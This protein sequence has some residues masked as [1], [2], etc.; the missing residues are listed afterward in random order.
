MSLVGKL[1]DERD[2]NLLAPEKFA[3]KNGTLRPRCEQCPFRKNSAPGWLG[4]WNVQDFEQM[5]NGDANFIC[6]SSIDKNVEHTCVGYVLIRVNSL[7]VSRDKNSMLAKLERLYQK[8]KNKN[9]CFQWWHEFAAH[10][11]VFGVAK[12]AAAGGK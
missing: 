3:L 1:Q 5:Y 12:R 9:D 6:H 7:K 8:I 10:H 4:P 2:L 11:K